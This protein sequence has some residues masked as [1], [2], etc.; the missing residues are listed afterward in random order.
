MCAEQAGQTSGPIAAC[1]G[2]MAVAN[3]GADPNEACPMASFLQEMG[4]KPG[5]GALLSVPGILF[6]LGGV[7][8]LIVPSVLVLLLA[9]TSI[10]LGLGFLWIARAIR[11]LVV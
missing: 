10:V 8:V 6:V 11:R 7:L 3:A 2:A 9:G 4:S 5:R 1:C